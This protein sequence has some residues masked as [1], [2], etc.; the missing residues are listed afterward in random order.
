MHTPLFNITFGLYVVLKS[1]HFS[2]GSV[3]AIVDGY[4]ADLLAMPVILT[5]AQEAMQWIKGEAGRITGWMV[6]AAIGYAALV[7]E[8][9]MP[10]INASKTADPIDVL[11]YALGGGLWWFCGRKPARMITFE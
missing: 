8:G 1:W 9:V 2:A 3:N 6:F 7:F 5:F 10:A 11:M 4:L